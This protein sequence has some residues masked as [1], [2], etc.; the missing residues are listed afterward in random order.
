MNNRSE[1]QRMIAKQGEIIARQNQELRDLGQEVKG[2]RRAV[3]RFE[4]GGRFWLAM[5]HQINENPTLQSEWAR[6]ISFLKMTISEEE[7][8]VLVWKDFDDR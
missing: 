2:L 7:F 4:D 5:Q 3:E 8:S 1:D 6:F